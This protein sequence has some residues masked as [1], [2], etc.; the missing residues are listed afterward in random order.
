M[1]VNGISRHFSGLVIAPNRLRFR[2]HTVHHIR[3][4]G[5]RQLWTISTAFYRILPSF[6]E[7]PLSRRSFVRAAKIGVK[8]PDQL[9]F[10]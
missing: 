9:L 6:E 2:A 1:K 3:R 4:A 7:S 10:H 8:S 5:I